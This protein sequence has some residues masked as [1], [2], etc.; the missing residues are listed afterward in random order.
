MNDLSWLIYLIGLS[1]SLKIAAGFLFTFGVAGYLCYCLITTISN[2]DYGVTKKD[3]KIYPIFIL[4]FLL[5]VLIVT[6]SQTTMILIAASEVG[7]KV[8]SNDKVVK[9]VDP[10]IELLQTWI[11]AETKRQLESLSE[12]K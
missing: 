7:E 12:K 1:G 11:E 10:A 5:S 3:I 8:V 9:T 6:P 2:D 4:L